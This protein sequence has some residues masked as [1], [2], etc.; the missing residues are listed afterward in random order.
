MRMTR[1]AKNKL[2]MA[3]VV[4]TVASAA[5]V[6]ADDAMPK[7]MHD[8]MGMSEHKGECKKKDFEERLA[9]LEAKAAE[10][11]QSKW[12]WNATLEVESSW[13]QDYAGAHTSDIVL[14]TAYLSLEGEISKRVTGFMSFLYE[15]DDTPLGVDEG[16]IDIAAN[17]ALSFRLGQ[18]YTPFGVYESHLINDPL[19]LELG[20][21]LETVAQAS[22]NQ[23][24]FVASAYI[25]NGDAPFDDEERA[26]DFGARLQYSAGEES[27]G[28]FLVGL[29]FNSNIA[30]SDTMQDYLST[31]NVV[32]ENEH[33]G[34]AATVSYNTD[35]WG[36][37]LE[38]VG[39]ADAFKT[40]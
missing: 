14:S 15:Q 10:A 21:S 33:S 28:K 7:G 11:P 9:A 19:T 2:S 29:D 35:A 38:Q 30:D 8:G 26:E 32:L 22:F 23:S 13:A 34:Y 12:K 1:F 17:D 16:Y 5:Q 39:V 4:G 24:G 3:I 31:N 25:Y 27:S 18:E 37:S 36:V 40:T 6:W 20:E